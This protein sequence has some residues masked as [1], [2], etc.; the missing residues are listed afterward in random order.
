MYLLWKKIPFLDIDYDLIKIGDEE[1]R[2]CTKCR[3]KINSYIN[4]DILIEE[5]ISDDTDENVADYIRNIKS[6]EE[7]AI[8]SQEKERIENKIT[9]Q[10]NNPLYDDIHQLAGDLRFIKHLIIIGI[11]CDCILGIIGIIGLL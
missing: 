10:K 5:V 8:E 3:S 9:A 11:V 6:K 4:G 2:L 1:Y 7:I